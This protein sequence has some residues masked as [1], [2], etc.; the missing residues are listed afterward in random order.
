[1]DSVSDVL[2]VLDT[3]TAA[4]QGAPHLVELAAVRVSEGEI[5]DQFEQLVR[6]EIPIEPEATEIH[7][8]DES[9]VRDAR[10]AGDV[11]EDFGTWAGD[12]WLV[13]HNAGADARVLGFEC[14]RHGREALQNPFL[15]TLAL[16][17]KLIPEAPDHK[18]LTLC[19]FLELED[20][21]HHRALPDAVYCWKVL[22]ECA[23]RLCAE[24]PA[25]REELLAQSGRPVSIAGR[26]PSLPTLP[27]RLRR[28]RAALEGGEEVTAL[29]GEGLETPA[30]LSFVPRFLFERR[31]KGYLEAQC[32]RSGLLK[33]YRIDRFRKILP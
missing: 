25:T 14:A 17:K 18:L 33:T 1:M 30:R 15:D 19:D 9:M 2:I 13:A 22:E 26:V 31:S 21:P 7:G 24:R 28:L 20:G 3:E 27:R 6:P 10:T 11:L 12:D 5:V 32:T 4:L 8:I 16:A 29:Y 23:E